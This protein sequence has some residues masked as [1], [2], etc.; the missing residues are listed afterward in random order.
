MDMYCTFVLPIFLYGCKTW[1]LTEVQMG[2]LEVTHSSCLRRIVGMK[3]RDTGLRLYVNNVARHRWTRSVVEDGRVEQLKLRPGQINIKDFSGMYRSAIRG[4]HETEIR[5]VVAERALDRQ[6][7]QD[8]IE[9][10]AP[11]Q[12]KKPQQ[13]GRMTRSCARRGGSG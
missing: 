9:N 6:V 7:W 11:L 12:F 2:R 5:A 1:A 13:F 4:C 3:L 10:L 8:A